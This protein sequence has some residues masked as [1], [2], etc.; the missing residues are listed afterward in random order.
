MSYWDDPED[1]NRRIYRGLVVQEFGPEDVD[2][3]EYIRRRKGW[4]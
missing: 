4:D 3:L 2:A 1:I